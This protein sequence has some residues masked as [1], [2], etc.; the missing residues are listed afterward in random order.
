MFP[1]PFNFFDDLSYYELPYPNDEIASGDIN[2]MQMVIQPL[3][4]FDPS[5]FHLGPEI[6]LFG[7]FDPAFDLEG[8]DAQ[9]EGNLNLGLPTGYQ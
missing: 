1:P 3:P 5:V 6:D 4:E 9:L 7:M 8:F 2:S